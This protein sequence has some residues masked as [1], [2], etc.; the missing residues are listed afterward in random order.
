MKW[1]MYYYC[2]IRWSEYA[3]IGL[4]QTFNT[5]NFPFLCFLS[6]SHRLSFAYLAV[7]LVYIV[8]LGIFNSFTSNASSDSLIEYQMLSAVSSVARRFDC[9]LESHKSFCG[10]ITRILNRCFVHICFCLCVLARVCV[11]IICVCVFD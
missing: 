10:E 7:C 5:I 6:F 1:I 3:S 4:S 9:L 11:H 2:S 8:S